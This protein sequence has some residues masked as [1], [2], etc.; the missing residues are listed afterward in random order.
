MIPQWQTVT[1]I[2]EIHEIEMVLPAPPVVE[3]H[4][5]AAP[6]LTFACAKTE[7][8]GAPKPPLERLRPRLR[9]A[10]TKEVSR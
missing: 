8:F 5:P 7:F 6:R 9:G 4:A 3:E 10:R 1:I 2:D